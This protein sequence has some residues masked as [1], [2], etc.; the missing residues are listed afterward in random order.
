[1]MEEALRK[2]NFADEDTKKAMEAY[3][4]QLKSMRLKLSNFA[5]DIASLPGFEYWRDNPM[6]G[7]SLDKDIRNK[8]GIK[9]YNPENCSFV[10]SYDN[11]VERNSRQPP[12]YECQKKQ[13]IRTN[14]YGEEVAFDC[15]RAAAEAVDGTKIR[16][17][18][19][20]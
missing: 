3:F 12:A 5:R 11:I 7:I 17:G 1:M 6:Q 14:N 19:V 16:R 8:S 4:D 9:E 13:V 20:L 18:P 15:L 10:S 2:G